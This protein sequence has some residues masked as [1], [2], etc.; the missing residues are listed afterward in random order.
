[1]TT[2]F[3]SAAIYRRFFERFAKP[4]A[5]FDVH[6]NIGPASLPLVPKAAINR[7]TPKSARFA[8]IAGR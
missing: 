4:A 6:P 1:M 7:R 8:T 5:R 2:R 3:C